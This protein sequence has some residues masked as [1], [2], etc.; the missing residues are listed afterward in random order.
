MRTLARTI[1]VRGVSGSGLN[2]I[3]G[4]LKEINNLGTH[5]QFAT[6]VKADV[7]VGRVHW[8]TMLGKPTIQEVNRRSLGAKTFTI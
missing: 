2:A 7:L 4:V 6:Q 3:A 5:A 1:L 8:K